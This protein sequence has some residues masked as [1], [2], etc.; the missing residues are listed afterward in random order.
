MY[1]VSLKE[2]QG[3]WHSSGCDPLEAT[4][5]PHYEVRLVFGDGQPIEGDQDHVHSMEEWNWDGPILGRTVL[6][7]TVGVT[8]DVNGLM[9]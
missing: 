3:S 7:A 9:R 1:R 8:T 6:C 2:I 5:G 4:N